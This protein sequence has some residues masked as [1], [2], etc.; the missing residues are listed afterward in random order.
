MRMIDLDSKVTQNE[1]GLVVGV[2]RQA[3]SDYLARGIIQPDQTAGEWL[4][5]YC[6]NLRDQA[7]ARGGNK[8]EGL[9][10]ARTREAEMSATLK[11]LQIAE[12]TKLLVPANEVEAMMVAMITAAKNELLT[13]PDKAA[14][15]IKMLHGIDIDPSLIQELVYESLQHLADEPPPDFYD[16]GENN[17]SR[18]NEG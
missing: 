9:A 13:I 8:Q 11:E 16:T 4:L 5:Q 18:T 6:E 7:A 2:S 12:K 10:E 17:A 1:F 14:Q 3:V 15:S